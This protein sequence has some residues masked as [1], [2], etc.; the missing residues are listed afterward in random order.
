[1]AYKYEVEQKANEVKIRVL[2]AVYIMFVVSSILIGIAV[3]LQQLQNVRT[4]NP[5]ADTAGNPT[6]AAVSQAS[7]PTYAVRQLGALAYCDVVDAN[8]QPTGEKLPLAARF[9]FRQ[10][11]RDVGQYGTELPAVCSSAVGGICNWKSAT[12]PEQRCLDGQTAAQ[13][14]PADFYACEDGAVP[15]AQFYY[16][17]QKD[18]TVSN[19]LVTW[20][21]TNSLGNLIYD[22]NEVNVFLNKNMGDL[23]GNTIVRN[24][25]T[26]TIDKS[27]L[28]TID[29]ASIFP[30]YHWRCNNDVCK[31]GS[32]TCTNGSL[33]YESRL[34]TFNSTARTFSCPTN[35][36]VNYSVLNTN[37]SYY[38]NLS[39][40]TGQV[41]SDPSW[42]RMGYAYETLADASYDDAMPA[43]GANAITFKGNLAKFKF[44]CRTASVTTDTPT[45]TPSTVI[46]ARKTGPVCVERVAP[47]NEAV[48]T[49]TVTNNGTAAT[50]I[51]K[52]EDALPQGFTYKPGSTKV[53]GSAVS[54]S[55]VT[56]VNSGASVKVTFAPPAGQ[57]PWT[58]AQGRTLTIVFTT[59]A[60]P[61]AVTGVNTNRVVVT[62][63]GSDSIDNITYQFEVAQTCSPVT[64]VFDEPMIVFGLSGVL[65][66]FGMYL[67]YAPGGSKIMK[68]FGSIGA[69]IEK[70]VRTTS[71][72]LDE[73]ADQKKQFEKRVLARKN[74]K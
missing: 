8:D 66:I 51:N 21:G 46:S 7:D 12:N 52:V 47:N 71:K 72:E 41:G 63:E 57:T 64:G 31:A 39:N 68:L 53:D 5:S 6:A 2:I 50:V 33:Q 36:Y 19:Y 34:C 29:T 27:S 44:V 11:R 60:S 59:I 40:T 48:F 62:P 24:G 17:V 70:K 61:T 23:A 73:K 35:K 15:G 16:D 20:P 38:Y 74:K 58:L 67:L 14:N 49:V 4:T 69:G 65:I 37:I 13:C 42:I 10:I 22:N 28:A 45:V 30:I 1:M 55:Y 9:T 32:A 56:T 25:I 18:S 54:D 3:R 26:Y 43:A